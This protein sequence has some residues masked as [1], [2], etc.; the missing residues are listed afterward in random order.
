MVIYMMIRVLFRSILFFNIYSM[1]ILFLFYSLLY[2]IFY[3]ISIVLLFPRSVSHPLF[4]A[5]ILCLLC[6]DHIVPRTD[7][8][9]SL[10]MD[11][12]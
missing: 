9:S 11:T 5:L 3:C 7:R 8:I 6:M 1:S 10:T 4:N 2:T 12:D